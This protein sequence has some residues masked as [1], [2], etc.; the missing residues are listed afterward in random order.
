[1]GLSGGQKQRISIARA[2]LKN[3]PVIILDD[4]SSALDMETEQALSKSMA[5]E[6]K[7][8]TVITIAHRV[9]SVKNCDEIIYLENGRIVERGTHEQMMALKGRYYE[10]FTEQYGELISAV[11][12]VQ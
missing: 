5:S 1:M 9:S 2:I 11:G 6:L 4:A 12:G 8:H 7:G 3:A 10:V